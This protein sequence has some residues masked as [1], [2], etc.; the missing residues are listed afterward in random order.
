MLC[1]EG[2]VYPSS[3]WG[4]SLDQ[5]DHVVERCLLPELSVGDWLLFS[6][7]GACGLDEIS[8]FQLPVYYTVSTSD[9]WVWSKLA[10]HGLPLNT[11]VVQIRFRENSPW[12]VVLPTGSKCRRLVWRWTVPWRIS[13]W[14]N[15]V[16]NYHL[17]PSH[18]ILPRSSL[19]SA[20][21]MWEEG[22]VRYLGPGAKCSQHS[23]HRGKCSVLPFLPG[24]WL[25]F[26]TSQN[27]KQLV[28]WDLGCLKFYLEDLHSHFSLWWTVKICR[29]EELLPKLKWHY[30]TKWTTLWR[31]DPP[32]KKIWGGG[33]FPKSNSVYK[34]YNW[35]V[36]YQLAVDS[37]VNP[38]SVQHQFILS[39]DDFWSVKKNQ[40]LM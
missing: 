29:L 35:F 34:M 26:F 24:I 18:I 2:A 4:P 7:M 25:F 21:T 33:L 13:P 1:A 17:P 10:C 39:V 15:T 32:K 16:R 9:W 12:C 19:A 23:S 30:A 28:A 31:W 8:S 38:V 11:N 3:L 37:R 27:W 5:L 14:F 6:N 20:F 22:S 36:L 40:C